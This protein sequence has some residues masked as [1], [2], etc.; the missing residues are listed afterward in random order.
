MTFFFLGGPS[1]SDSDEDFSTYLAVLE[2][3]FLPDG[4][5]LAILPSKRPFQT[6]EDLRHVKRKWEGAERRQP[7]ALTSRKKST[8]C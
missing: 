1:L 4:G 2:L 6:I 8:R 7:G 3:D 5:V